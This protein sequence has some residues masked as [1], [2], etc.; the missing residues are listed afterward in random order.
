[1][2]TADFVVYA[3]ADRLFLLR[4]LPAGNVSLMR[5][6]LSLFAAV[7]LYFAYDRDA[8]QKGRGYDTVFNDIHIDFTEC[9]IR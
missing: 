9:R 7:L 2:E 5:A 3:D 1:M 6:P 4:L 8:Y